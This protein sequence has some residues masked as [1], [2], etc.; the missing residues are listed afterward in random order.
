MTRIH[1]CKMP[2]LD[3]SYQNVMSFESEPQRLQYFEERNPLTIE[4]NIKYD[5]ERT[6]INV[7]KPIGDLY[8]YDYLYF[9]DNDSPSGK[10]KR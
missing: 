4:G 8:I 6:V 1:F 10:R 2:F 5:G 3:M 7:N 9:M